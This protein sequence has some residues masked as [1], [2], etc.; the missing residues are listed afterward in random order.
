PVWRPRRG[1]CCCDSTRG[2]VQK[3]FSK[4]YNGFT[5]ENTRQIQCKALD[6]LEKIRRRKNNEEQWKKQCAEQWKQS[7][8]GVNADA[9]LDGRA[10]GATPQ[11]E[12]G[13]AM[14]RPA[15]AQRRAT[16]AQIRD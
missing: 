3:I 1:R 16:V 2:A 8:I 9:R 7:E 11:R 5:M 14:K 12:S 13:V 4:K 15:D 6:E 10:R